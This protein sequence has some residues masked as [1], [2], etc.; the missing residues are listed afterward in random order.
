MWK[1]QG[2]LKVT[3]I[4]KLLDISMDMHKL[5]KIEMQLIK[6]RKNALLHKFD[7]LLEHMLIFS[8]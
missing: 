7:S 3:N 2:R 4:N 6:N 5:I 8:G 1:R